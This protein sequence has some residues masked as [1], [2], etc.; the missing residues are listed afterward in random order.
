MKR[1]RIDDLRRLPNRD[2]RALAREAARRGYT[3]ELTGRGRLRFSRPGRTPLIVPSTPSDR[4]SVANSR[5]LL[6]R[7]TR[8]EQGDVGGI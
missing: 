1:R 3:V 5:A 6:D 2:A 4:R 8:R 7:H